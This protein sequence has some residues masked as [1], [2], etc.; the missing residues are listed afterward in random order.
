MTASSG[1]VLSNLAYLIG[2]VV[3]AFIGGLAVWLYHRQP[4]SVDANV[5]S[6][7]RGLQAIAPDSSRSVVLRDAAVTQQQGLRLRPRSSVTLLD[8]KG[9]P[10]ATDDLVAGEHRD[11]P[12]G[13]HQTAPVTTAGHQPGSLVAHQT[14]RDRE[15]QPGT[16]DS[17]GDRAG[18]ETG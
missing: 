7:Q 10:T 12:A 16:G 4:K 11:S 13:D 3:L 9:E 2:A 1:V 17:A 8:P 14:E 15:G 5:E 18:A 6:F